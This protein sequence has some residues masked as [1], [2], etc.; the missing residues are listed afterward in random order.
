MKL[1]TIGFFSLGLFFIL[2][3]AVITLTTACSNNSPSSSGSA[4]ATPTPATSSTAGHQLYAFVLANNGGGGV[5]MVAIAGPYSNTGSSAY[6]FSLP[7][8]S[9]TQYIVAGFFDANSDLTIP[10]GATTITPDASDYG[11]QSNNLCI[12]TNSGQAFYS[13]THSGINFTMSTA[14]NA[15]V[16]GAGQSVQYSPL[17]GSA[18]VLSG[19]ISQTG[20]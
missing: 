8:P 1:R 2:L 19:T 10:S 13:T 6:S 7:T 11:Q 5:S 18:V 9:G 15:C 4:T 12:S 16:F 20:L 14:N 3:T 17:T